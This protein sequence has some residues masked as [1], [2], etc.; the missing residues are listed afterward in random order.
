MRSDGANDGNWQARSRA[1]F[2]FEKVLYVFEGTVHSYWVL[3]VRH[4]D[5]TFPEINN[6]RYVIFAHGHQEL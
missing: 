4:V 1:Q 2:C 6:L 5:L 3:M